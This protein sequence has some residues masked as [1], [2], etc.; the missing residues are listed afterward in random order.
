MPPNTLQTVSRYSAAFGY[1]PSPG[2][3]SRWAPGTGPKRTSFARNFH[4]PVHYN[5]AVH[6][7]RVKSHIAGLG[8]GEG[9]GGV[10]DDIVNAGKGAVG[11][12]LAPVTDK[13][14][15]L[16]GAIKLI[17]LLSGVAAATG[18]VNMLR[19]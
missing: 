8:D 18:V 5:A 1:A 9:L 3:P 15:Q 14:N 19:R 16:E 12:A 7:A 13:A 6:R 17:L 10:F 4:A 2:F 11:A